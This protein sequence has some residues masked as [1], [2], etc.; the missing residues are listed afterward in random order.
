[1]EDRG[2]L[3]KWKA[4]IRSGFLQFKIQME[5]ESSLKWA[6]WLQVF[7]MF[8]GNGAFLALWLLFF[9]TFGEINGWGAKEV[10]GLEGFASLIF[11][12]A[13]GV[14]GGSEVMVKYINNGSLDIFLLR[15]KNIYIQIITSKIRTSAF[16]DI[17]YGIISLVIFAIWAKL[18]LVSILVLFLILLPAVVILVNF[19][20][21]ASLVG[22]VIP[23][24]EVLSR[25]VLD[26]ILTPALVPSGLFSKGM[27]FFLIVVVP[28]LLIGGFLV[29]VVGSPSI[30]GVLIV[31]GSAVFWTLVTLFCL[32]KG[33]ARYESGNL[34][35][36]RGE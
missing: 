22:F 25:G 27:R 12:L 13:F 11:G 33:L 16:G 36:A 34:V 7:G 19:R 28:A 30:L 8:I 21:L 20:F 31:F 35:G 6:F 3:K 23:D 9:A 32:E 17:L 10:V 1:M 15:P 5:S 29:E 24:A 14:F 26:L 4:G 18:D 2:I